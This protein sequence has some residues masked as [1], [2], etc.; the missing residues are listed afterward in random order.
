M[1]SERD[2]SLLAILFL[3][4]AMLG[5]TRAGAAEFPSKPPKTDFFVDQAELIRTELT[6]QD[7]QAVCDLVVAGMKT[8]RATEGLE[9]GIRK[10]GELLSRHFPIRP[11]D[12]DE[13]PNSLVLID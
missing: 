4:A 2:W 10:A 5:P 1:G 11:D 13:L 7:W 6:S 3:A 8:G 9:A 12:V